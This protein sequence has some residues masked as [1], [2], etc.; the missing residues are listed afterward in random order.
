MS[1]AVHTAGES[2]IR[3]EQIAHTQRV[4]EN[5]KDER[6]IRLDEE[7]RKLLLKLGFGPDKNGK[8]DREIWRFFKRTIDNRTRPDHRW[9]MAYAADPQS[10]RVVRLLNNNIPKKTG[11][12]II[13]SSDCISVVKKIDAGHRLVEVHYGSGETEND[14]KFISDILNDPNK[15]LTN[16]EIP[17][18]GTKIKIIFRNPTNLPV[19]EKINALLKRDR[20]TNHRRTRV[21]FAELAIP[22]TFE[23]LKQLDLD[24]G[25]VEVRNNVGRHHKERYLEIRE[26]T[27]RKVVEQIILDLEA[28][29]PNSN[30]LKFIKID[31]DFVVDYIY[32]K[33]VEEKDGDLSLAMGNL[34]EAVV[35]IE[36]RDGYCFSRIFFSCTD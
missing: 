1:E 25:S 36:L 3:S 26:P 14:L 13:P 31:K 30:L 10:E 8:F 7:T 35:Q 4:I 6:D 18:F 21:E 33:A 11:E 23:Q 19:S 17:I 20:E 9:K 2:I 15:F 5:A 28:N 34:F 22:M 16:R 27:V 29:S 32:K 24:S 12:E